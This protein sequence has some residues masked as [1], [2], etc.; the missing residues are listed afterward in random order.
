MNFGAGFLI[1]KRINLLNGV[2][3]PTASVR[4]QYSVLNDPNSMNVSSVDFPG[5]IQVQSA[6]TKKIQYDLGIA[7]KYEYKKN[8]EID[9]EYNSIWDNSRKEVVSLVAKYRF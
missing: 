4:V 2:I 7:L 9:L 5:F 6:N 3:T 8:M 1:S